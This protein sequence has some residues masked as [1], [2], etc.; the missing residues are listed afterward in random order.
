MLNIVRY[1][2]S[3]FL[4]SLVV[5][6]AGLAALFLGPGLRWSIEF[7]SG[8]AATV[9]FE[10]PAVQASVENALEIGG[11]PDRVVQPL[12]DRE[13]FIRLPAVDGETQQADVQAALLEHVGPVEA[14]S[15]D[16]VSE[17]VAKETVRNGVFAVLAAAAA[18]LAYIVWAFRGVP[19]SVRY[20]VA[21]IVALLHD[22]VVAFALA[23]I[24][25]W[26]FPGI[27]LELSTMF[28]I[29]VLT[30]LGYSIND[31]IVVFDRIRENVLRD[32]NRDFPAAVSV[33]ILEGMGR[34]IN[35][36]FT[37]AL[38]L[39]ALWF[40]GPTSIRDFLFVM[41][42]GVMAGTY[43]SIFTASSLLVSWQTRSFG[44]LPFMAQ[45]AAPERS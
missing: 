39:L 44:K 7:S 19:H 1:R 6:A 45:R 35:T 27:R 40:L 4:L 17:V 31:T 22:I 2:A 24:V 5:I 43:S 9:I 20:G 12:G 34:S 36:S 10:E 28:L 32:P 21:A 42:I 23:G 29:G 37:T 26:V 25:V 38:V 16:G 14:Y 41:L 33:S 8:A 13:F 11:F 18:I 30:L 15:F 3:F